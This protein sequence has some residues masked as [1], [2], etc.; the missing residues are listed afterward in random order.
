M[1]AAILL[2]AAVLAAT[3]VEPTARW[4]GM[5]ADKSLQSVTPADGFLADAESLAKVWK[6]WRA[7]EEVPAVDFTKELIL[8]GVV[9][10]PNTVLM[11][12]SLDDQGDLRFVVAGTKRGG[13]GFGYLL[14][15]VSR[16]GVKTVN[17]KPLSAAPR[18][19]LVTV[20]VLFGTDDK[21]KKARVEPWI[22]KAMAEFGSPILIPQTGWIALT[23]DE[24][25]IYTSEQGGFIIDALVFERNGK[26][27]VVIDGCEG[28][29][30]EE[31]MIVSSGDQRVVKF[32][33]NNAPDNV[34]IAI[35]ADPKIEESIAVNVVGTLHTGVVAIGGETTGTT[36]SANGLTWELDFGE[37][38]ELRAAAEKL[39]GKSVKFRG[40]LKRQ[41]GV[42]IKERWIVTVSELQQVGK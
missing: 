12:P 11:R 27:E 16:E 22:S 10:G 19:L 35:A 33:W 31:Y 9:P 17:G 32:T 34:F 24:Q 39:D 42:E 8:V 26:H 23:N 30:Q 3:P 41:A 38:A 4:N 15:K 29:V 18:P 20:K 7:D 14:L 1:N 28:V 6:S 5:I 25:R 13:P 36:I 2:C 37:N 40:T 21:S